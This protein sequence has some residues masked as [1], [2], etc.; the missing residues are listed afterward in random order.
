[1]ARFR[2]ATEQSEF[3]LTKMQLVDFT[4]VRNAQLEESLRPMYTI[5]KPLSPSE[6]KDRTICQS[7]ESPSEPLTMSAES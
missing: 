4:I 1:M 3:K 6:S 7:I 5:Y 2:S